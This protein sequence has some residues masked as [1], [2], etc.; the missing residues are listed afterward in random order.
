MLLSA[1]LL[2]GGCT[3]QAIQPAPLSAQTSKL[4][5]ATRA[6]LPS[7][8]INYKKFQL[9]NGL[10]VIVHEDHK[11][12]VV[13][14]NVWYKVGSKDEPFGKTGFAHLFEHLMFNGSENFD[15]DFFV[16]FL[17]AGATDMNGTTNND[18]T[19]YFATV[20]TQALD[21]ALW[22]ESD[23]MGH[24]IN[25][26]TQEKLD[27]QRG[28]VQNEKRQG[29]NRPYG[30]SWSQ[31]AEDT[32]P[33]GH[34]YS[35]SVIGSMA[36][37]DAAS[38]ED[39]KDWFK[40]YY[41]PSNA[42]LVL[43]GDID[44]KTAREKVS[45]YFA[46]IEPGPALSK[47]EAWIA[48]RTG[49]KRRIM[50]D[51]VPQP[52]LTLSWN[53]PQLGTSELVEL[54]VLASIL[55]DGK[56]SRLYKR[57][58]E[59][60]QLAT[61][62][63]AFAY[64]R[65][66]AG[67]FMISADTKPDADL[68]RVEAII[69]EELQRVI[70]EGIEPAE[71]ARTRFSGMAQLIRE[72]ERVGGFG[73]KSD[74]LASGEVYHNNPG[75]Y[76]TYIQQLEALTPASVQATAS[77][78]LN[79][80][81]YVQTTVP[82]PEYKAGLAGADRSKLP[83]VNGSP[84]LNLPAIE[85]VQ[86]ANGI[87]VVLASRPNTPLVSFQLQ[88]NG[89][90][91]SHSAYGSGI[92]AFT[93]EMLEEGSNNLKGSELE[94]ALDSLGTELSTNTSRDLSSIYGSALS[95]NLKPSLELLADM[96][97]NPAF[98]A[99]SVEQLKTRRL[100]QLEQENA[101]PRS[102]IRRQLP[103]VLYSKAD[104]PYATPGTGTGDAETLKTINADT[105]KGY[106]NDWF[107]P[108]NATLIV[109]G[110]TTME[111][112]LPML[113]AS[114]GNWKA[115]QTALPALKFPDIALPSKPRV[116]LL[117]QPAAQQSTIAVAQLLP[118]T[119]GDDLNEE[120]S[121]QVFNDLLGGEFTSRI[122][123]NLREEKRWTYGARSYSADARGQRPF[124]ISTSVQTDKTGPALD[125]IRKELQQ[126][127]ANNPAQPEEIAKYRGNRQKEQAG[128]YETNDNLLSAISRVVT[129][130]LPENYLQQYGEL[131]QT[132]DTRSVR[133]AAD[134]LIDPDTMAWIIVGDLSKVEAEI[135]ALGLGEVE[136]IN[137]EG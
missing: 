135:R 24:F 103:E 95:T 62:V 123:M 94:Q 55:G 42:V 27:I 41:G 48:R 102:L 96:V 97:T 106:Y 11:A 110:D 111:Q 68:K 3:Q 52:Q 10:T 8:A 59:Q 34:P 122:N 104:H 107:R 33:A 9:D 43:A 87:N 38:L 2:L 12:P 86:L 128:R 74:I 53:V 75:H 25:A 14:V 47:P 100:Q 121:F 23:R 132:V 28:V 82:F 60:E 108:D 73:G 127:F 78:W 31:M 119:S 101:T 57:L 45:K 84:E 69:R 58:V 112:L 17:S 54:E 137:P 18:R 39:V 77:E 109:V 13:A 133:Q 15:Q 4:A 16:P 117:N 29:E 7:V 120:L 51:H 6:A 125:E 37:L 19:N 26:V 85:K 89:G 88:F 80:G 118:P 113:K 30:K 35:W 81:V 66:L 93:L 40:T 115:P 56:S 99:E 49:E 126:V 50:Q 22:M 61:E 91:A 64:G 134:T 5:E 32:F 116:Y 72:T 44:E 65:Q 90:L 124:V 20:P 76:Q 1:A 114:F 105:V 70:S 136:V 71:V 63:S 129:Y 83:E 92:P 131:L 36:D 130:K 98:N 21:M 46:D 79:D 67:Q